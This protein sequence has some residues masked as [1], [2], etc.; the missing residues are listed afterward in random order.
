MRLRLF[1][2]L[3]AKGHLVGPVTR[4]SIPT[5]PHEERAPLHS[6]PPSA[7]ADRVSRRR[8]DDRDYRGRLLCRDRCFGSACKNDVDLAPDE[9]G[10]DLG[11]ALGPSFAPAILDR[12]V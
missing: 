9:L 11:E 4:L 10:R 3:R 8:E 12:D 2:P 6:I 5:E 7:R 1:A